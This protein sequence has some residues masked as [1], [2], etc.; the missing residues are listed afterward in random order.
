MNNNFLSYYTTKRDELYM[1]DKNYETHLRKLAEIQSQKKGIDNTH[2][3]L[4]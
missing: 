1:R 3:D 2:M 4:M